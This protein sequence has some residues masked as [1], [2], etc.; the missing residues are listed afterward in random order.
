MILLFERFALG[1][2]RLGARILSPR[3][4]HGHVS[5][6][7]SINKR[8]KA[9]GYIWVHWLMKTPNCC[10]VPKCIYCPC[11]PPQRIVRDDYV[12]LR[13][14][15][16]YYIHIYYYMSNWLKRIQ[17]ANALIDDFSFFFF[18]I[19]FFFSF[20]LRMCIM[21]L[22][23][24]T[25]RICVKWYRYIRRLIIWSQNVLTFLVVVRLTVY[26]HYTHAHIGILTFIGWTK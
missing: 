19:L 23:I 7:Y 18:R 22:Y 8:P 9:H 13:E 3:L 26:I 15:T 16:I 4:G 21:F 11:L 17:L 2:L 20:L 1:V 12:I 25:V 5:F 24:Y 14:P 10:S 6:V